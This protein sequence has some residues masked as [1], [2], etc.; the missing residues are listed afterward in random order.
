MRVYSFAHIDG[1]PLPRAISRFDSARFAG[2]RRL[3]MMV[4]KI[5]TK[6]QYYDLAFRGLA[7]NAPR[8]WRTVEEFMASG[9]PEDRVVGFRFLVPGSGK[10]IPRVD[11]A[12]VSQVAADLTPGTYIISEVPQTECTFQGEFSFAHDYELD[13]S[14][15]G[16]T[17]REA[18]SNGKSKRV[19]GIAAHATLEVH[20]G[21]REYIELRELL[22]LYTVGGEAPVIEFSHFPQEIGIFP[23]RS[24]VIW[25]V[26]HY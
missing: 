10:F 14:Y 25:E 9:Y 26:R 20:L 19:T 18:M 13:Y 21:V 2:R 1:I 16:C 11:K 8:M 15:E 24:T 4:N 12:N 7:G 3:S 6:E 5:R 22:D 17:L 23:G